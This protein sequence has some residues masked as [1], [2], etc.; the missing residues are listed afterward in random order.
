MTISLQR[1]P[2]QTWPCEETQAWIKKVQAQ[3]TGP[4]EP[5]VLTIQSLHWERR[6]DEG[7]SPTQQGGKHATEMVLFWELGMWVSW[8]SAGLAFSQLHPGCPSTALA[9]CGCAHL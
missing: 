6:D 4:L 2:P 1:A 5:V 7:E 8:E 3:V 9:G